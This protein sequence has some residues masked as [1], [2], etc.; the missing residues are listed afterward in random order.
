MSN[1]KPSEFLKKLDLSKLDAN[2]ATLIRSDLLAYD[3]VDLLEGSPEFEEVKK[4]I[5]ENYPQALGIIPIPKA[6]IKKPEP[7][8]EV[9]K[10]K[11]MPIKK[12]SKKEEKQKHQEEIQS[13]SELIELIEDTVKENPKDTETKEYLELLQDT[14]A[15]MKTK[16]FEDG[17]GVGDDELDLEYIGDLIRKENTTGYDPYYWHIKYNIFES[18][19]EMREPDYEHVAQQVE[20]GVTQGE[21]NIVNDKN[22]ESGGWWTLEKNMAKGGG[23]GDDGLI[24]SKEAKNHIEVRDIV[25]KWA[26]KYRVV[27]AP[28]FDLETPYSRGYLDEGK[29]VLVSLKKTEEKGKS[30]YYV[31]S[32]KQKFAKGGLIGNKSYLDGLSESKRERILKNIATHY[33]ISIEEAQ[34]EVTDNEAESLY[35]YV[36]DNSLRMEVYNDLENTRKLSIGGGVDDTDEDSN[37]KKNITNKFVYKFHEERGEIS[38]YVEDMTNGNTV[39]EFKYPDHDLPEEEREMQSSPVDDGFMRHFEDISGLEKYLKQ[40]GDIPEDAEIVSEVEAN[41]NYDYYKRGGG[42]GSG[43]KINCEINAMRNIV[44]FIYNFPYNFIESVWGDSNMVKAHLNSKFDGFARSKKSSAVALLH[45]ITDLDAGNHKKLFTW[46]ANNYQSF[47]TPLGGSFGD[48]D[49]PCKINA[50]RNMIYF[51]FNY[52]QGFVEKAFDNDKHLSD[53]F[54][55]IY[56]NSGSSEAV[57][58]FSTDLSVGNQ[59]KLFTWI[60]ENYKSSSTPLMA[61]GGALKNKDRV[62]IV[63][64]HY[65]IAALWSSTDDE[66]QSFDSN[67]SYDEFDKDNLEKIRQ[68]IIKFMIDNDADLKASG[69]NDEQIGHDLWLTQVGHGAGFWDR[70]GIDKELGDRL[71]S[72]SKQLGESA[73][74]FAQDGKVYIDGGDYAKGGGIGSIF[75]S[76]TD[77]W[78]DG[79]AELSEKIKGE[80]DIEKLLAIT[81]KQA[82]KLNLEKLKVELKK[83]KSINAELNKKIVSHLDKVLKSSYKKEFKF[84]FGGNRGSG[85]RASSGSEFFS[86][87]NQAAT[88][89]QFTKGGGV[90]KNAKYLS[91]K[92]VDKFIDSQKDKFTKKEIFKELDIAISQLSTDS[93]E[94]NKNQIAFY[95]KVRVRL[96]EL[97]NTKAKGGGVDEENFLMIKRYNKQISHHSKELDS[98]VKNNSEIPAWIVSKITRSATDLSDATH[99]MEGK[100]SKYAKGGGVGESKPEVYKYLTLQKVKDGLKLSIDDEG[101]ELLTELKDDGK[102]D[103]DIY[104][105]LFE[106]IHGN[107]E[108]IF[109]NDIGDSGFGL[110][111][112]EG[113]TDGY[114]YEGERGEMYKT[115]YPESAKVYWFP[116][117]MVESSLDTMMEHGSVTFTEV[118]KMVD[119]GSVGEGKNGYVAFYKGKQ[120]DVYADT[121]YEAQKKAAVSFKAKKSYE[122]TVVLA[123]KDGEQ[124]THVADFKKG[125]GISEKF[126]TFDLGK[127]ASLK[128]KK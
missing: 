63:L 53:T 44:Y 102:S 97:S 114:Y 17:G 22:E 94:M 32:W 5:E 37:E 40:L 38:A 3:N 49:M 67:Y 58:K 29:S 51:M 78:F 73:Y 91:D 88:Y 47:S 4:L 71:S 41:N 56:N 52:P 113:I 48:N 42:V 126:E 8:V 11:P 84:A 77:T 30:T 90:R 116:N 104:F 93:E 20:Q 65:I 92:D 10:L 68:R 31:W 39:W 54:S 75:S 33:G 9:K 117:Y 18:G 1:I 123:E 96:E 80:N 89:G 55:R 36:T 125:G 25:D 62:E 7:I 98:A 103:S 28:N 59:T 13:M 107:S 24:A 45:F 85:G 101:I 15:D 108:Y 69:L 95:K 2:T 122:V 16:K 64:K 76:D 87:F 34:K 124:V 21:L 50:M 111:N 115:D 23:I 60:A 19:F 79:L 119:G 57:L 74:V 121:S 26:E 82:T 81:N 127:R 6:D 14:L 83:S 46:V 105:E 100:D 106:N 110:T 128:R 86:M 61:D 35:E 70:E 72:A 43:N 118:D 109:H 99:F 120:M 66:D 12:S 112:V 27:N